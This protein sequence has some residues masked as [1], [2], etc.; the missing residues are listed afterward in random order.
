MMNCGG[1][2]LLAFCRQSFRLCQVVRLF[3]KTLVPAS[4]AWYRSTSGRRKLAKARLEACEAA[5]QAGFAQFIV[6]VGICWG[7]MFCNHN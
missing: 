6:C 3:C 5:S 4:P 7:V 1:R 2:V